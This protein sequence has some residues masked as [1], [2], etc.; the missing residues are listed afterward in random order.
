MGSL[1]RVQYRPLPPVIGR[2]FFR[3][4]SLFGLFTPETSLRRKAAQTLVPDRSRPPD[5]PHT[6]QQRGNQR[7]Y[8]ASAMLPTFYPLFQ[9]RNCLQVAFFIKPE[10]RS[11][12]GFGSLLFRHINQ[13]PIPMFECFPIKQQA[14]SFRLSELLKAVAEKIRIYAFYLIDL[15]NRN[16]QVI[17]DHQSC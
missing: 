10:A 9:P 3:P 1:V 12:G 5:G 2:A 13:L 8:F 6:S 11:K 15:F 17:F 7:R 14:S 4:F 16:T